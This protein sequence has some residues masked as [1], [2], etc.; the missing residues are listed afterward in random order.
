MRR[1]PW[2]WVSIILVVFLIL[3][4]AAYAQDDFALGRSTVDNGG[5][6]LDN[7]GFAL[8]GAIGQPDAGSPLSS[9]GFTLVGGV[10]AGGETS[11]K[12]Y[13]PLI[14]RNSN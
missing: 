5:G 13:L 6:A 14:L 7:G 8:I 10:F 2:H 1:I 4:S 12:C 11:M 9:T 3:A